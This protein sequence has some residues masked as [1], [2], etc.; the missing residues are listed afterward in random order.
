MK[1]IKVGS[2]FSGVGAFDQALMKLGIDYKTVFSCDMDKYARQSYSC[3]YG[4]PEYYPENVYDRDIPSEPLD[5]YMTS[6]PCQAF[7]MS[8]S[9]KGEE[10]ERGILFYN[11]HEFI[12][13]NKPRFFIFENVKGL[14]S[15]DRQSNSSEDIGRTFRVWLNYL[16]G[17]SVNGSPVLFAHEEAVPYHIYHTVLN[18]KDFGVPHNRSRVFIVGIRDD[19]DNLF[20][21][22]KEIPLI[23]KLK[24][25]LE[26]QVDDKYFLSE[27][28][29]ARFTYTGGDGNVIGTT[30]PDFRTIGERDVVHNIEKSMS[31]L[32]ATDYKQPK[33]IL[34]NSNTKK[35]YERATEEDS[36]DFSVPSSKTRRGRVGKKV[37]QTLDCQCT[38]GVWVADYRNDEGLRIRKDNNSPCLSARRH[39]EK[40][41]ST[42]PP[43]VGN[44][45]IRRLTPLE[46]FRL[47]GFPDSFVKTCQDN[48]L[49]D[50][51]LYKQAG[52]SITVDVLAAIIGKLK[53]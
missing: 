19:E 1:K 9:R 17:K 35:G 16:G 4:I 10:D 28:V 25:L 49:S 32:T 26:D 11:S 48:G 21:F 44:G 36:I 47:Q 7:S 51:Q 23:L 46:C 24:D 8:G 22:P 50:T 6:P 37:A 40:D 53:L 33:Q 52:N 30:K 38:Q 31:C 41:I 3:N 45:K 29:Q 5:I 2:D 20:Q 15:H 27:E 12:K 13:K 43:L 42:M 39:S 34:I 14:L 18:T